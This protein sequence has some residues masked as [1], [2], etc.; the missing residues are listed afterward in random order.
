MRKILLVS[1]LALAACGKGGSPD[2][3]VSDAWAR[4]TAPG[5]GSAAA[6]MTIAN[7]GS[8]EDRLVAVSAPPPAM[9][10]VH[11]T[12]SAGG[13]TSMQAMDKGVNLTPGEAVAL[14]PLGTH[15]MITGLTHALK[16]GDTL[17]LTLRFESSGERRVDV[18]VVDPTSVD[19]H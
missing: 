11:E 2:V 5:Q 15:V 6:Y 3:Q 8:S 18:R 1:L 12:S 10:M 7:R 19:G 4:A 16:P 13:V 17:P 9:A 14:K